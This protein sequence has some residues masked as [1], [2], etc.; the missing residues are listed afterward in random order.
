MKILMNIHKLATVIATVILMIHKD[1]YQMPILTTHLN[2][3]AIII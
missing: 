2:M 1:H 3:N